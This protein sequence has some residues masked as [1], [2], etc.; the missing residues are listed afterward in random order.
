MPHFRFGETSHGDGDDEHSIGFLPPR[1]RRILPLAAA[2][3]ARRHVAVRAPQ[4]EGHAVSAQGRRRRP[5]AGAGTEF[6]M[7]LMTD[8][9][10]VSLKSSNNF[11][12]SVQFLNIS[13]IC[14][15]MWLC[16]LLAI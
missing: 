10:V 7:F 9:A 2:A 3:V 5:E 6:F 13:Q 11:H 16:S 15:V 12:A 8:L 14:M 1:R 4:A